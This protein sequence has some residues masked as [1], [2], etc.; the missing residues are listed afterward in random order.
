[1]VFKLWVCFAQEKNK[2]LFVGCFFKNLLILRKLSRVFSVYI[3]HGLSEQ[4][5]RLLSE[6]PFCETLA[7]IRITEKTLWRGLLKGFS[8]FVSNFIEAGRNLILDLLYKKTANNCENHHRSFKKYC[9]DFKTLKRIFI[10]WHGPFKRNDGCLSV[11]SRTTTWTARAT[12]WSLTTRRTRV[13]VLPKRRRRPV[14]PFT[15]SSDFPQSGGWCTVRCVPSRLVPR[16][17]FIHSVGSPITVQ[18]VLVMNSHCNEYSLQSYVS[19]FLGHAQRNIVDELLQLLKFLC[20][21]RK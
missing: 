7:A 10:F 14:F 5:L 8:Q 21:W 11:T 17:Y 20:K 2:Y 9:F 12:R 3:H 16:D 1:M 19:S 13:R 18:Y 15:D 6:Q 4:D